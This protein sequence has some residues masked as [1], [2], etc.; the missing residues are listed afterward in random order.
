[1]TRRKGNWPEVV[2]G[3]GAFIPAPMP[4]CFV[5]F[6]FP[7]AKVEADIEALGPRTQD[8]KWAADRDHGKGDYREL[9]V[10]IFVTA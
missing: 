5:D 9:P 2:F 6:K 10:F 1:M 8:K 3:D 7:I 4:F